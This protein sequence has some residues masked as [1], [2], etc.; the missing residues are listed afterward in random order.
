M[1]QL[2]Y[3]PKSLGNALQRQ[4]KAKRLSQKKAGATFRL[5]QSTISNIE[6]GGPGTR[7]ETLFRVLAALDLEMIIRDKKPFTKNEEGW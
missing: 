4:R 2:V 3:S 1:E 6:N 5:E 7:I